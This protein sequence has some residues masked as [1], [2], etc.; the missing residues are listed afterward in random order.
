VHVW[1]PSVELWRLSLKCSF[2]DH[3]QHIAVTTQHNDLAL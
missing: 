3:H 2:N 1:H